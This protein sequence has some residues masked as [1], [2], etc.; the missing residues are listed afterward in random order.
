MA[1][2]SKLTIKQEKFCNKYLEC[3]N[4]SEAYRYAYDCSK[5]SDNSVWCNASQLLAD[6]KVA[7]RLEYL[8]NHLAEAAGITALQ[9]IREHQKIAFSDATR[10]R[11]GWMSLKEFE[12]LTDDE[13]ACIRSVETKQ[14]KRTTPM[15]DEVID[16]QVKITC[17]DKQKALD[18]I[19]S[20]LGYNAPEKIANT[21]S[22]GNDI[23]QPTFN[24][25][26]L[27]QLIQEGKNNE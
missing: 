20:M 22:K 23:P 11:N 14:T 10:I 15:G 17:Y 2:A 27:F 9:I 13:K 5:M 3:G 21:D 18:S 6:T 16:E 25:E 24:V 7:Q 26:R 1:K 19:V 8:K 4:A 12:S